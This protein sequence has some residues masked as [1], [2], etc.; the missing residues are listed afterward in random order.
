MKDGYS[1]HLDQP[2]F[3]ATYEEMYRRYERI[4]QRMELNWSGRS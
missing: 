1:F 2:S 3:D 4:L